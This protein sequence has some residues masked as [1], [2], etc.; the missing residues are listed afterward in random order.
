MCPRK[1]GNSINDHR[2]SAQIEQF[3]TSGA[4]GRQ[5]I[6]ILITD[7]IPAGMTHGATT[8]SRSVTPAR[9]PRPQDCAAGSRQWQDVPY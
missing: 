2:Q 8:D 1:R 3:Q 7:V 5:Q 6:E 4:D 9:G